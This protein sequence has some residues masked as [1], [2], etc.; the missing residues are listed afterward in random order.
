MLTENEQNEVDGWCKSFAGHLSIDE[1]A[2]GILACIENAKSLHSDGLFL[3]EA[4][5]YSRAMSLL[6]SAME[7]IGKISVLSSMAR[8]PKQ[9]QKL[10]KEFWADFRSHT[11]KTTRAF[12]HTYADELR[13]APSALLVAST[14]QESLSGFAERIRQAGLYVDYHSEKKQW[15]SPADVSREEVELW[16]NRIEPSLERLNGMLSLRLFS[17]Q[18]LLIQRDVFGPINTDRERR[19]DLSADD[20]AEIQ[21]RAM[22]SQ[23]QYWQRLV[24]TGIIPSD[25]D[26]QIMGIQLSEFISD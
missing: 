3:F 8:I 15:V 6:V 19:N 5:R 26:I 23:K 13:K 12:V 14:A 20:A 22:V 18:A 25:S 10:W 24:E 7:E 16:L 4:R 9:N 1:I 17:S 11:N 2:D 21:E